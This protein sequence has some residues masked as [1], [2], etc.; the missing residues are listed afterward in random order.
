MSDESK[1]EKKRSSWVY[2]RPRRGPMMWISNSDRIEALN[3][4]DKIIHDI[5][6][7][8]AN[9]CADHARERCL[10]HTKKLKEKLQDVWDAIR[11]DEVGEFKK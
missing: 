1:I 3:R 2:K 7:L 11:I 5:E 9:C 10:A 4:A 6:F 8:V